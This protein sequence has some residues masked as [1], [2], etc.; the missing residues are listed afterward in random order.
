MNVQFR[1]ARSLVY[2]RQP[3]AFEYISTTP[4]ADPS[5]VCAWILFIWCEWVR[6]CISWPQLWAHTNLIFSPCA[7][8]QTIHQPASCG[9]LC[10]SQSINS[11]SLQSIFRHHLAMAHALTHLLFHTYIRREKTKAAFAVVVGANRLRHRR[12][13]MVLFN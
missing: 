11:V 5:A 9:G 10:F 12:H 3:T 6:L 13:T 2:S 8:S 7:R 4:C 1:S